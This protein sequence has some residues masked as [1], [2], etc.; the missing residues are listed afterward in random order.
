[1]I[2]NF[3]YFFFDYLVKYLYSNSSMSVA[4][5]KTT[6]TITCT[7]TKYFFAG[8]QTDVIGPTKY[9]FIGMQA[10]MV[11]S[12]LLIFVG[13]TDYDATELLVVSICVPLTKERL[14]YQYTICAEQTKRLC[15]QHTYWGEQTMSSKR[16]IFYEKTLDDNGLNNNQ[17][18]VLEILLAALLH[19]NFAV[20]WMRWTK[21]KFPS[22][23]K[24]RTRTYQFLLRLL[25]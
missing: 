23:D 18:R 1:M 9:F 12:T 25:Q 3:I 7:S 14:G 2:H 22:I 24:N 21:N 8:M 11:G 6:T 17:E 5:Y 15:Y 20:R 13:F 10:M 19:G 4:L 16:R